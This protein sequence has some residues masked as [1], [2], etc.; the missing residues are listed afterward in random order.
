MKRREWLF[1]GGCF[2]IPLISGAASLLYCLF[3]GDTRLWSSAAVMG[4]VLGLLGAP[5]MWWG[6]RS[7]PEWYLPFESSG[8]ARTKAIGSAV[9]SFAAWA[10]SVALGYVLFT[11]TRRM[12]LSFILLV[13]LLLPITAAF[14]RISYVLRPVSSMETSALKKLVVIFGILPFVMGMDVLLQYKVN[15]VNWIPLS[16]P[17]SS[18]FCSA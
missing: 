6:R 8:E 14:T 17:S 5:L 7:F 12:E 3:S 4:I 18:C 11:Y 9:A 10:L 1:Y 15:Q 13:M 16:M 2:A